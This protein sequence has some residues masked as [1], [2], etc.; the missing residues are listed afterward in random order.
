M[1][2]FIEY[3]FGGSGAGGNTAIKVEYT[4]V[5]GLKETGV[6]QNEEMRRNLTGKIRVEANQKID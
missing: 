2:D 1:I 6:N 3:R 4:L 5:V